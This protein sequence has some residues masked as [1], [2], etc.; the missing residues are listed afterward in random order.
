V[1]RL[2]ATGYETGQILGLLFL[3]A[4]VAYVLLRV[5]TPRPNW[6]APVVVAAAV[7]AGGILVANKAGGGLSDEERQQLVAGCSAAGPPGAFCGCVVDKLEEDGYD[8]LDEIGELIQQ[9]PSDPQAPASAAPA[10]LLRA[11]QECGASF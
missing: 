11:Y 8:T 5:W 7:V 6:A 4:L 3:V 9:L 10:P 2:A 1:F